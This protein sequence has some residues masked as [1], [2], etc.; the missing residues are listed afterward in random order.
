MFDEQE[1]K[2]LTE[3][4]KGKL[5]SSNESANN[6]SE[7]IDYYEDLFKEEQETNTNTNTNIEEPEVEDYNYDDIKDNIA[8]E[9]VELDP[10][11]EVLFDGGPT[12][13]QLNLWKKQFSD[14]RVAVVEIK[15]KI[16]IFRT[17]NRLEYKQLVA[18]PNLDAFQREEIVC[19]TVTLWP[20][21]FNWED[22]AKIDAGIPSTYYEIIMDESGFTNNYA[23]QVI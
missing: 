13:S 12:K 7:E 15:D 4:A 10:Y 19:K 5:A 8:G 18:I 2:R 16:F 9:S 11:D 21:N 14:S 20:K 3:E 6:D 23:V 1:L 22:L 17:L